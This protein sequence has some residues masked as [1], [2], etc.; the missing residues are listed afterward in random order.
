[1]QHY[2]VEHAPIR[3]TRGGGKNNARGKLLEQYN[4]EHFGD[5]P[6]W[7]EASY[8]RFFAYGYGCQ[9]FRVKGA[10]Q[11]KVDAE[12]QERRQRA[13]VLTR[14]D[15]V[16][17]EV[18]RNL[19]ELEGDSRAAAVTEG[20]SERSSQVSPWLERTRWTKFLDGVRLSEAA[21]LARLP[22]SP[23][24]PLLVEL[25]DSIDRLVAEAYTSVCEDRV[26]FIG[27]RNI[28]CFLP[29]RDTYI[30]GRWY[31]SFKRRHIADKFKY[32][33]G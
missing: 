32:G 22:E 1:L 19:A 12:A 13:S 17:D 31:G 2:N 14:D 18:F 21:Q 24:E 30:A 9:R 3:R 33:S 25:S 4:R 16:S 27:Q 5:E 23:T 28:T 15:F 26:N 20:G 7:H 11:F 29:S 6:A 10:R 8:Q